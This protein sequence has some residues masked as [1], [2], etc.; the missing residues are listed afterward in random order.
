[1]QWE[2]LGLQIANSINN[3]PIGIQNK[4]ED[5]ENLDILTPNR[6]ILGRNNNRCPT[7]PLELAQDYKKIIETNSKI[8][9]ACFHSWLISYVPTLIERPKWHESAREIK[10]GDVIL[11]LKS[12]QEF[13]LRYQYGLVSSAKR[14]RD[15]Y[16]RKIEVEYQNHNEQVKRKTI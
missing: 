7:I 8:F 13:D 4:T 1:M 3:L 16:V 5:I 15:G 12:V 9:K 10:V 2:S 6:L 11:F 14:G